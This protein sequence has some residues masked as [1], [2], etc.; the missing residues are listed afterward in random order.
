MRETQRSSAG[1]EWRK[2]QMD[3]TMGSTPG[4]ALAL[5]LILSAKTRGRGRRIGVGA[6]ATRYASAIPRKSPA[7]RLAP[8]TRAP[9][10]LSTMRSSRALEGFTEPP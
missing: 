2:N 6:Y 8:P 10:T 3:C 5:T 9:L 7:F 1:T 4:Q